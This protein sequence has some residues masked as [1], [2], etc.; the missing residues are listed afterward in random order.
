[1]TDLSLYE[2]AKAAKNLIG[3]FDTSMLSARLLRDEY[4]A[5]LAVRDAVLASEK[6]SE[7]RRWEGWGVIEDG[8]NGST[9]VIAADSEL[10]AREW[11]GRM[12]H[13]RPQRVLARITA[14]EVTGSPRP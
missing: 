7:P 9:N 13:F 3:E 6:P 2:L 4:R 12:K 11:C 8:A 10:R 1:M 14:I 5:L